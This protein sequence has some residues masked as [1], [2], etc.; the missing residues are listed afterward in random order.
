MPMVH[1]KW[2]KGRSLEDKKKVAEG[3]AKAMESIGV[4]PGV[5]YVIFEDIPKEDWF[6]PGK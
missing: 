5:T 3:V 2:Y 4:P 6:T 1:V